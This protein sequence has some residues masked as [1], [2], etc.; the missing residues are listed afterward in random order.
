V[1]SMLSVDRTGAHARGLATA[2]ERLAPLAAWA[3]EES[4]A[5]RLDFLRDAGDTAPAEAVR[6]WSQTAPACSDVVVAGIGGSALAARLFD[7]LR[8]AP[9]DHPRLHVLDTVDPHLVGGLLDRLDP[10]TVQLIGISKSGGTLETGAVFCVFEAWMR[11]ALGSAATE[12]IAVVCGEE[13]NV[14][15]AHAEAEG[16]PTFA[17]P[18]GVGGRFSALTPV[19]LLPAA[20]VGVDPVALVRG[21]AAAGA[22]CL[23]E[24]PASNPALALADIHVA[25]EEAGRHVTILWPYGA[26]LDPLGPWW[27]Q[28]VGESL[29]KPGPKGPMGVTAMPCR[30]PADQHSL[31]Q[32]LVEGP[33]DKLTVFVDAPVEDPGAVVPAGWSDAAGHALGDLL[34]AEREATTYALEQ[35]GRPWAR[36]S[37][38]AVDAASF[39]QFLLTYEMAVVYWARLI[40]V[41]PF[42]QPGVTLGKQAGLARLRGEP[43]ELA[44]AVR[45]FGP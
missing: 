15:R 21:A 9:A 29:G 32:L 6:A 30:G 26:R 42:G 1:G 2:P 31:L 16:Y 34:T 40:G 24:D 25:A 8:S 38:P 17:I 12:R 5:G 43:A 44:A 39:G 10:G 41:N 11:A 20:C 4:R 36:V 14:F 35:S 37:L 27:A 28:L 3:R 45:R 33:D 7:S 22:A 13:P 23:E 18:A 19:G